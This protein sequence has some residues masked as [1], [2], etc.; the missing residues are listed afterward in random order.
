MNIAFNSTRNG[1][2]WTGY[3]LCQLKSIQLWRYIK[4]L[5]YITPEDTVLDYGCGVGYGCSIM[6][7][8]AKAVVGYDQDEQA[9]ALAERYWMRENTEYRSS[10][11]TDKYNVIVLCEVLE[12][13]ETPMTFIHYLKDNFCC[14]GTRLIV[15]VPHISRT[16]DKWHFRHYTD[17]TLANLLTGCN[18]MV[19]ESNI[20]HQELRPVVFGL[21]EVT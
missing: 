17:K 7:H 19:L 20:Y 10:P 11:P 1:E 8:K 13:I 14:L 6:S 12:H 16:L 5:D 18:L 2:H 15:T 21:A 9:I 3:D 4:A